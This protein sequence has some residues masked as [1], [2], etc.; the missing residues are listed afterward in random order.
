MKV[1]LMTA[2]KILEDSH[3]LIYKGKLSAFEADHKANGNDCKGKLNFVEQ[4]KHIRGFD[5][6]IELSCKTCGLAYK[7]CSSE[8]PLAQPHVRY[9]SKNL[10][11]NNCIRKWR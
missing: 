5:I 8:A 7:M 6:S 1:K 2:L 4:G 3:R 9:D 11:G 10:N